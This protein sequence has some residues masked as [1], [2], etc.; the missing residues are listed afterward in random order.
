MSVGRYYEESGK[1]T[2]VGALYPYLY[3]LP[4]AACAG[5]I[6]GAL[7]A[8]NPLIFL[9]V[10]VL[11]IVPMA[12]VTGAFMGGDHGHV[13]KRVITA[14]A[15]FLSGLMGLYAAWAAWLFG[16]SDWTQNL[17]LDP[18]SMGS[19]I[20]KYNQIGVWSISDFRPTGIVLWMIWGLEAFFIVWVSWYFTASGV[21]DNPYCEEFGC[22]ADEELVRIFRAPK[23]PNEFVRSVEANEYQAIANLE[24]AGLKEPHVLRVSLKYCEEPG[25]PYFLEIR[26][27][28]YTEEVPGE[29]SEENF[30]LL[31]TF[32]V[33]E[34]VLPMVQ[35]GTLAVDT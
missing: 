12:A 1:F 33:P 4:A 27:I 35:R 13:R 32:Q 18:V 21:E 30:P 6:Y 31:K 28:E 15:G 2:L 11:L 24:P 17:A 8:K 23:D 10:I 25:T 29:F 34:E 19:M 22:W 26:R 7:D 20:Y 3:G 5:A 14:F 16:M 9:N